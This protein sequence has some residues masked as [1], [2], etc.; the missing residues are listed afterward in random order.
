MRLS[1]ALAFAVVCV[2]WGSTYLAIRFVIETAPP[3][4]T[5]GTRWAIAGVLLYCVTRLRGASAPSRSHWGSAFVV[6]GLMLLVAH[7]AVVWAEQWILSGLASIFVATVPLWLVLVES[8]HDRRKPDG[9]GLL[10]LLAGFIGVIIL[11]GDLPSLGGS[12]M[13]PIAALALLF[14]ALAWGLGS[15]YSRSASL[16]NSH[17]MGVAI[18]MIAGGFLLLLTSVATGE[19]ANLRLG[20]ISQRSLFAWAYLI[21]FGSLVGF[22]SYI[23]LLKQATPSRIATYA[24]INPVVALLLGWAFANEQ[25]TFTSIVTTTI[26]LISVAVITSRKFEPQDKSHVK[27]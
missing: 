4:F 8:V 25:P 22:T 7:G 9:K 15:F 19:L 12:N 3:F 5:A 20:S 26:I 18:Q 27:N 10:A 2:V 16:P 23:W 11:V 24:Y 13:A 17:F 1:V 21:V 14:G 6:G